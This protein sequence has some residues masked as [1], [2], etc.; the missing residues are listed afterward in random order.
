MEKSLYGTF[1]SLWSITPP[2][3]IFKMIWELSFFD[4]AQSR[5]H[6]TY[7]GIQNI[8]KIYW[9][10]KNI[11]CLKTSLTKNDKFKNDIIIFYFMNWSL[12]NFLTL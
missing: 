3:G 7:F 2:Q 6:Y 4:L 12:Y 8:K 1:F 11:Q 10:L 5:P 9:I